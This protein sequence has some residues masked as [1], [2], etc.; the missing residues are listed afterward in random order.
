[1]SRGG[2]FSTLA[3]AARSANRDL[4]TPGSRNSNLGA[5][6]ARGLDP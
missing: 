1:V 3:V 2:S 4:N 6:P 5:R